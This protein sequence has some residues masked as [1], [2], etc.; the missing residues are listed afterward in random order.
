MKLKEIVEK[1][2]LLVK[3]APSSLEREVTGGYASDLLSDVMGNARKDNI[4]V[5]LQTH[6]NI[7]AVAT[8]KEM[9]G[10][11]L[12][13]DRLPEEEVLQKAEEERI[14]IMITELSTFEIVGRLYEL[15][16]RSGDA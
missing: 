16:I 8:L 13:K 3:T 5:T 11:I 15:G 14:P 9:A 1:L 12:V 6:Q 7:V 4:W 10:I 2:N